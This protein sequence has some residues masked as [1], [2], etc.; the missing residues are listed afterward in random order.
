MMSARFGCLDPSGEGTAK[1]EKSRMLFS[2]IS[3]TV[4]SANATSKEMLVHS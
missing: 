3:R 1:R 4:L 2:T